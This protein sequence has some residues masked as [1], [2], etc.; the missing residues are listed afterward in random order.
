MTASAGA[1][2]NDMKNADLPYSLVTLKDGQPF[3]S[4]FWDEEELRDGLNGG[5]R[6]NAGTEYFHYEGKL[7]PGGGRNL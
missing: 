4:A 5:S 7:E 3:V 2:H 1:L 6:K